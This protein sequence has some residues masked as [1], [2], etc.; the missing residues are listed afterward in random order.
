MRQVVVTL[1]SMP[2]VPQKDFS[3]AVSVKSVWKIAGQIGLVIVIPILIFLSIGRYFDNRFGTSPRF[4]FIGLSV[5]FVVSMATLV[6]IVR[7]LNVQA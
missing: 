5:A 2:Q 3:I 4:L 1:A 7:K 6:V